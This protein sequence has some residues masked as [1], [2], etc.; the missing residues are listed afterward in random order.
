MGRKHI[1]ML[2]KRMGVETFYRKLENMKR[3]PL[4]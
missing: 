1:G 2:M 4:V 3:Y